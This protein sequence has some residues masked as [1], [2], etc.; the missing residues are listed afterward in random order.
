MR[1]A[2]FL[3]DVAASIINDAPFPVALPSFHSMWV[4][5]KITLLKV[6]H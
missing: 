6:E 5:Y 2:S 4:H 3:I 1:N